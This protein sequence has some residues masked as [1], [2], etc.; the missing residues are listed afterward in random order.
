MLLKNL[1]RQKY[2]AHCLHTRVSK[3]RAFLITRGMG[4]WIYLTLKKF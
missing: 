4:E 2:D 3:A 1:P